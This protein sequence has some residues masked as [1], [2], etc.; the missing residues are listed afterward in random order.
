MKGRIIINV[1]INAHEYVAYCVNLIAQ[2]C[3]LLEIF[4]E[5]VWELRGYCS[6]DLS[7]NEIE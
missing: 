1:P 2:T 4:N 6:G 7:C 5:Q 3:S